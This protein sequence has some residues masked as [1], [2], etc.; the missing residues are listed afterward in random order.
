MFAV[1][2]KFPILKDKVQEYL[3]IDKQ[4]GKMYRKYKLIPTMET[5]HLMRDIDKNTTEI[6][7]VTLYKSKQDYKEKIR[8]IDKDPEIQKLYNWLLE[9][10]SEEKIETFEYESV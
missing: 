1:V 6:L 4:A 9:T 5:K 2:Y 8:K 10:V 3:E 7:V